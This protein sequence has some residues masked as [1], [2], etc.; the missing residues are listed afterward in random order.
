MVLCNVLR[1]DN[2]NGAETDISE[3]KRDLIFLPNSTVGFKV[4]PTG[5][6]YL[7]LTKRDH[8]RTFRLWVS[9]TEKFFGRVT[10]QLPTGQ[11]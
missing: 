10:S 4:S 3:L 1:F 6:R 5:L 2:H 7:W 11:L 9:P 8:S